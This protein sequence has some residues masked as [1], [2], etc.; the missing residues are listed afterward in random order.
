MMCCTHPGPQSRGD[1]LTPRGWVPLL[2]LLESVPRPGPGQDPAEVR[3]GFQVRF[4]RRE[5]HQLAAS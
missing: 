4:P 3:L 2:R 5:E 1:W